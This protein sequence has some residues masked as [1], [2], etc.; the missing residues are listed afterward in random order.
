LKKQIHDKRRKPRLSVLALL[1]F[2]ALLVLPAL[3]CLRLT[4]AIDARIIIAFACAVGM[5]TFALYGIDKRRAEAG[6]WRIPER[7]LHLC[8]LLGGWPAAFLAQ[9]LFRHKIAKVSYQVLFWLIILAHQAVAFD[10]MQNWRWSGM[11]VRTVEAM[12]A[13]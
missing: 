2:I 5:L 3:A 6:D 4:A 11:L 1:S 10:F 9:R 13:D 8:E 7:M 12:D